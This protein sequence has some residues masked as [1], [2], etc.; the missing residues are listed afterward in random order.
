MRERFIASVVVIANHLI[1]AAGGQKHA[2][3]GKSFLEN[4]VL[5]LR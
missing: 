1:V 2:A 3:A 5:R 4:G